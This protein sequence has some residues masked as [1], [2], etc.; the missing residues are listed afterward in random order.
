[1]AL[2]CISRADIL[3][4]KSFAIIT[5]IVKFVKLSALNFPFPGLNSEY[6][7]RGVGE[8]SKPCHDLCMCVC[9]VWEC[10]CV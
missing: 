9:V 10:M 8:Q 2:T 5:A 6:Y 3:V 4:S 7:G 1:M